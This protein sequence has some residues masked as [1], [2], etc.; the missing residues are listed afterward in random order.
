MSN[1][2]IQ[3]DAQEK[4]VSRRKFLTYAGIVA[5]GGLIGASCKKES[6]PAPQPTNDAFDLGSGDMGLLNF[7]YAMEQLETAFFTKLV[8]APYAGITEPD[9]AL[10]TD[11]RYHEL[12]HRELLNTILGDRAIPVLKVNIEN[13]NFQN[14]DSALAVALEIKNTV[15]ASYNYIGFLFA[16]SDYLAIAAK[17]ISVEARHAAFLR[18][19]NSF[20]SF[21]SNTNPDGLDAI[22]TPWEAVNIANKYLQPKISA[23][24]LPT[25]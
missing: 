24:N 20:G 13:I 4:S 16:S 6:K 7:M 8:E 15:V 9:R 21:A 5:G 3:Q 12:A 17:I 10:F 1:N 18:D 2:I 22:M 19:V 25:Q 23:G 11:I 14:K